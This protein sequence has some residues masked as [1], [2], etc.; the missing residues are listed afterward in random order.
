MEASAP[1][2]PPAGPKIVPGILLRRVDVDVQKRELESRP[3][4]I[5]SGTVLK[6]PI[7]FPVEP[8][9]TTCAIG[10]TVAASQM[11][12]ALVIILLVVFAA[13]SAAVNGGA[14]VTAGLIFLIAVIH[15]FFSFESSLRTKGCSCA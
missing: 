7:I 9:M 4:M 15:L 8:R 14:G 1:D 6:A 13:P 12:L 11:M 2:L 3:P 10:Y 5:V